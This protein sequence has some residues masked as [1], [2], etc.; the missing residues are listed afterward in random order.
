[1]TTQKKTPLNIAVLVKQVPSPDELR[2]GPDGRLDRAGASLELNPYCRRAVSKGVQLA[3]D[4]GGRCTVFTMGPAQA[5]DCLREAIAWGADEGVLISD[6]AFA[7]SDTLAT[8]RTLAAALR[9][10]G[11]FDLV[12]A[13]RNS[14]DAETGQTPVQVAELLDLPMA[15]GVREL[16]L[17]GG[18]IQVRC[19]H[20][21]GTL[22]AR[23][24]LPALITCAERL[25]APAKVDPA[26]R[27]AVPG[28]R[29]RQVGAAD[30][31]EG[32][33]G[34]PA[35][36]T[37]VGAVQVL[38]VPRRQAYLSTE[39]E[40]VDSVVLQAADL[41]HELGAFDREVARVGRRVPAAC[42]TPSGGAVTVLL[43]PNRERA[44]RELLGAA[45]ELAIAFGTNVVALAVGTSG[46]GPNGV[47][48]E[49]LGAWGADVVI[50]LDPG[51]LTPGELPEESVALAFSGWC[52]EHAP[53]VLLAPS[54][55]W[56]REVAGRLAA[57]LGAGLV[58]DAIGLAADSGRLVCSKPAFNGGMVA[59]V[60]CR[61]AIQM[62]TVRGGMLGLPEP[63]SVPARVERTLTVTRSGRVQ[64]HSRARE[65]DAD[66]LAAAEVVVGLGVGVP[67][68]DYPLI[69]PLLELLGAELAATRKVTDLG[70]QPRARQV[71]ITGRS[72][73]PRLYV[74]I[75]T[76]GNFNHLGG[77][78]GADTILAV[79][80]DPV[81]PVFASADVGIV[82]DWRQV[83][84][85]LVA[86]LG[87]WG[88]AGQLAAGY[89]GTPPVMSWC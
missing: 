52:A 8:A 39:C 44:N 70:W 88:S 58:G 16:E 81:A 48:A 78:Q 61:S 13:G 15:A 22:Q 62:A 49:V 1:M 3:G 30:L 83:L 2:M 47:P 19:E 34:E 29:I 63:R 87:P 35:S 69:R 36:P 71:G 43:E 31:G 80:S 54:T 72:V 50:P 26:G 79:N 20:D 46:T 85:A 4:T 53:Q 89:D 11:P 33:W 75:G 45:A 21:D 12:L 10:Y 51:D 40:S 42:P 59:A 66:V 14:V 37:T 28:C 6:A 76:S 5:E 55:M 24:T 86:A 57:R 56:G 41:L 7:G 67:P 77:V 65:D 38:E 64:V 82:G 74:A 17:Q 9:L 23:I 18:D 68:E 73:A 32:P 84:P 27:A 25:I 60:A